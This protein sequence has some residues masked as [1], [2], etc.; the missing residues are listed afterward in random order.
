MTKKELKKIALAKIQEGKT[1]Q[2][3]LDEMQSETQSTRVDIAKILKFIP[4]LKT[5]EK[6]QIFNSV[7]LFVLILTA[8]FKIL[9]GIPIIIENGIKWLPI[10]FILPMLNL[11]LAYGVAKFM[12]EY[13]RLIAILT[14]L[15][16]LRSLGGID[17]TD[18]Y[19]LM[20]L[21]IAGLLIF[22]SFF[23]KAKFATDYESKRE[24]Y[25]NDLGENRGRD[26]ISFND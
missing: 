7:L 4:P 13:Y 24:Y 6:Y 16:L 1:R 19:S 25:T 20:D 18:I 10:L 14:I 3:T 9:A 15:S 2:E 12:G 22:L 26:I 5:R 23:L 21:I 8:G 11:V 17:L